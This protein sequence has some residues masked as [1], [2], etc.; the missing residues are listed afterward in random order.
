M[1][2]RKN[3]TMLAVL[4][5]M[6][7][8]MN[9][10]TGEAIDAKPAPPL[11]TLKR[12]LSNRPVMYQQALEAAQTYVSKLQDGDIGWLHS[13]PF[14]PTPRNPQYY[15]LMHDLLNILQVLQIP[16]QGRI[17]EIGCG[18]GWITEILLMLGF[19]VDALEPSAQLVA[20]AKE[21]CAGLTPHYRHVEPT[22]IRF[23]LSTLEEIDFDDKSFDAILYFDA[24]HHVVHEKIAIEKSFRFLKPGAQIAVVEGAWH[25][26]FKDL[27]AELIAEMDKF[28]TLENPFSTEYLDLLLHDAGFTEVQRYAGINGFFTA[29]QLAQPLRNFASSTLA[30]SNNITARKPIPE[31]LLYP[32]C[33]DLTCKTDLRIT[34]LRG[35]IEKA[36]KIARLEIELENMG[37][38]QLDNN[39]TR[40]GHITL[41][42]RQGA[43]GSPNFIECTQRHRLPQPL[44]PGERL[45]TTLSFSLPP[46]ATLTEWQLDA[47]AEHLFWFSNQG[48]RSCPIPCI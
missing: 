41:A 19:T 12:F 24:L 37:Q 3:E 36:S 46:E 1:S 22:K 5:S 29:E 10:A 30:R 2:L 4:R 16:A 23:H 20:I 7:G 44:I 27:E 26:D 42:M 17:L 45:K 18:S 11:E 8:L 40:R 32:S 43:P 33:A 21:R 35:G 15:R 13:K 39:P 47:V 38:T 31:N 6:K 9:T 14:D 34:L 25:P 28:G 48:V